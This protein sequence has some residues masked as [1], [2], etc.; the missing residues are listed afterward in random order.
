MTSRQLVDFVEAKLNQYEIG[1]VI[2]SK[3][4]LAKTYKMFVASNRLSE[5]FA[6]LKEEI[7]G[8]SAEE[9]IRVPKGLEAKVKKLFQQHPTITW[10][11]AVRFIID[12]DAP[13]GEDD[14]DEPPEEDDD[15]DLDD[16]TE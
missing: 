10:H 13:E 12:P 15:E 11:Q 5:A 3:E 6:E 1:K 4:T 8:E 7:E 9:P 16:I 14:E 2:P